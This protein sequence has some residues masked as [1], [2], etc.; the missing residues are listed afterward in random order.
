VGMKKIGST[1]SVF[2]GESCTE[3]SYAKYRDSGAR[4]S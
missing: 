4:F 3:D 2:R 1:P